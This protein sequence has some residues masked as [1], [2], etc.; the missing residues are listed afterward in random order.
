MILGGCAGAGGARGGPGRAGRRQRWL[1]A[2]MGWVAPPCPGWRTRSRLPSQAGSSL[3]GGPE[4]WEDAGEGLGGYWIRSSLLREVTLAPR[5]AVLSPAW[6]PSPSAPAPGA[7]RGPCVGLRP[8]GPSLGSGSWCGGEW[9]CHSLFSWQGTNDGRK[10][11]AVPGLP[12]PPLR[13][14]RLLPAARIPARAAQPG[15][16]ASGKNRNVGKPAVDGS[17]HRQAGEQPRPPGETRPHGR[18][19]GPAAG[20]A[21]VPLPGRLSPPRLSVPLSP[22]ARRGPPRPVLGG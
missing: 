4:G 12:L 14:C 13:C 7:V 10:A 16:G 5:P 21:A 19:R 17:R 3:A 9:M 1:R 8:H 20:A 15:M 2:A 6:V 11:L 22:A 18:E